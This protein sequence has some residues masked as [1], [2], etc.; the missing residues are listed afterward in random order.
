MF[1]IN[2][3]CV[4]FCLDYIWKEVPEEVG[5]SK[6][7]KFVKMI[8]FCFYLPNGIGGPLINYKDYHE[9]VS[10]ISILKNARQNIV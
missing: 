1:W 2:S 9:G 8:A 6:F 4:S 3:R 7:W 10:L 5:E